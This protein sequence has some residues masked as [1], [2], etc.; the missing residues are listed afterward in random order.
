MLRAAGPG[1]TQAPLDKAIT[2][3]DRLGTARPATVSLVTDDDDVRGS[4]RDRNNIARIYQESRT[5]CATSLTR[6]VRRDGRPHHGRSSAERD[7]ETTRVFD[8]LVT[9]EELWVT[10]QATPDRATRRATTRSISRT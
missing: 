7:N 3:A 5:I 6:K 4:R 2:S 10:H 8:A 1:G 9:S